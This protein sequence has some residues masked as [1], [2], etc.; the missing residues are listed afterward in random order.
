MTPKQAEQHPAAPSTSA[1]A[2]ANC[3]ILGTLGRPIKSRKQ[4]HAQW[5]APTISISYAFPEIRFDP[6]GKTE[7]GWQD[8]ERADRMIALS[9]IHV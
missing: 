7:V 9:E 5:P 1:H 6:S 8:L 4:P 2:A 3:K